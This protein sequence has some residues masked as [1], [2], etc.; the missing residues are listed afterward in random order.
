MELERDHSFPT[1][2]TFEVPLPLKGPHGV[3]S[4]AESHPG[5]PG[6]LTPSSV[7]LSIPK[8]GDTGESLLTGFSAPW[9]FRGPDP[10]LGRAGG[11]A[12][13]QAVR[14]TWVQVLAV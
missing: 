9:D 3:L 8:L 14:Q 7:P 11:R 12:P 5:D 2:V 6:L 4:L 10:R 1:T 13:G